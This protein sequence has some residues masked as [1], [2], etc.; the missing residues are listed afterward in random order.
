MATKTRKPTVIEEI[1]YFRER[2]S[3]IEEAHERLKQALQAFCNDD[4][5]ECYES[6]PEVPK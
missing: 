4:E 2:L 1:E 3:A 5:P 6:E